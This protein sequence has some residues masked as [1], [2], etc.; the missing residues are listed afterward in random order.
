[1]FSKSKRIVIKVDQVVYSSTKAPDSIDQWDGCCPACGS[2]KYEEVVTLVQH[3]FLQDDCLT[4]VTC[5]ACY[6]TFHYHYEVGAACLDECRANYLA[7]KPI[8]LNRR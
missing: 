3:G 1:M 2:S 8:D 6:N 5:K 4:L 7:D